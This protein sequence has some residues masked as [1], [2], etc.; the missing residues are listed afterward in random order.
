M[1]IVISLGINYKN[2]KNK[3]SSCYHTQ[4]RYQSA[5][6]IPGPIFF[7]T[8]SKVT[9]QDCFLI[10]STM[11]FKKIKKKKRSEGAPVYRLLHLTHTNT[12]NRVS[13]HVSLFFKLL[14]DRFGFCT[15]NR[16]RFLLWRVRSKLISI[17]KDSV[18]HA[19]VCY[20]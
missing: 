5:F 3:I 9:N 20:N 7:E 12:V 4:D 11:L 16:D 18:V 10:K 2:I 15:V 1:M 14:S 17:I 19:A 13:N 8:S 6:F